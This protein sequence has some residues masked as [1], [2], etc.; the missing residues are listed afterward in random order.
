[1][2]FGGVGDFAVG[3]LF[4]F[5]VFT[6]SHVQNVAGVDDFVSCRS[7]VLFPF[8]SSRALQGKAASVNCVNNVLCGRKLVSFGAC[9]CRGFVAG[10]GNRGGIGRY[11][12]STGGTACH[13]DA[14][15]AFDLGFAYGFELADVH[16]VGIGCARRN[17]GDFVAAVVQ[18]VNSQADRSFAR[19]RGFRGDG[20]AV[21]VGN[22]LITITVGCGNAGYVQV[23]F[24]TNLDRAFA[25]DLG[26]DI[27]RAVI[28]GERAC[29]RTFYGQRIARFDGFIGSRNASC[30]GIRCD[31]EAFAKF[32]GN[33]VKLAAVDGIGA[34]GGN[35]ARGDVFDLAFKSNFTNRHLVTCNDIITTCKTAISNTIYRSRIFPRCI[36]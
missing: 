32:V 6:R 23:V 25:A 5:Q 35:C 11:G 18:S 3:F 17:I 9:R 31:R 27:V 33:T 28:S 24:Q 14:F 16:R 20:H 2:V 30:V 4:D 19:S 26:L 15:F 34:C 36:G 7:R 29:T 1:M 13:F 8:G 21:A 12:V 22:S 10:N